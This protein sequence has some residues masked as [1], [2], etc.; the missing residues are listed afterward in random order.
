M[1]AALATFVSVVAGALAGLFLRLRKI[2]GLLKA[3]DSDSN[4]G[5]WRRDL[6]HA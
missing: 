3:R 4:D 2:V 1:G 5:N 6:P